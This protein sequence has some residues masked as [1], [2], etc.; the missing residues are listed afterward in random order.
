M[1]LARAFRARWGDLFAL[2]A[3]GYCAFV[4]YKFAEIGV[5]Q[6][7]FA[8]PVGFAVALI[9]LRLVTANEWVWL[10]T[11]LAASAVIGFGLLAETRFGVAGYDS[12]ALL[13]SHR[14]VLALAVAAVI[15]IIARINAARRNIKGR[16]NQQGVAR[17]R[18]RTFNTSDHHSGWH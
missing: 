12:F 1:M 7:S 6:S 14:L 11:A 4:L 17:S 5:S 10:L 3:L 16:V 8:I 13:A 18:L 9:A 15:W 2:L